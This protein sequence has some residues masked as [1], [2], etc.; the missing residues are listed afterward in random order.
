M[1]IPIINWV[2]KPKSTVFQGM[3]LRLL[4]AAIAITTKIK[5]PNVPLK[6][7]ARL[8]PL[9]GINSIYSIDGCR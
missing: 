6:T 3:A 2:N 4:L 7:E 8:A 9:E 5:R 1:H